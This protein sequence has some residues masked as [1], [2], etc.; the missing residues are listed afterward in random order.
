M[1]KR[2]KIKNIKSL[3]LRTV[4][5]LEVN[6]DSSYIG[7]SFV[8]HNSSP[9]V[10]NLPRKTPQIN[11]PDGKIK[12]ATNVR[13][14]LIA[15]DG[16]KL[17]A[18]DLSQAELRLMG[19]YAN[20]QVLINWVNNDYDIH[21]EATLNVFYHG[22]KMEYDS[23]NPEHKKFRKFMKS[24]NFGRLYGG[25]TPKVY[26]AMLEKMERG[27]EKPTYEV[28][29]LH[30]EW[31]FSTFWRIKEYLEEM[32]VHILT[33]HWI[34][35]KFGRRRRV[36]AA[37]SSYRFI[38]EEAVRQS[39]NCVDGLTQALTKEGWKSYDEL[40]IN[41]EFLTKNVDTGILEWQKPI[42]LNVYPNYE[43]DMYL[44]ENLENNISALTTPDHRWLIKN[45]TRFSRRNLKLKELKREENKNDYIKLRDNIYSLKEQGLNPR[46]ISIKLDISYIMVR[47]ILKLTKKPAK[48]T[49][50][51][52]KNISID[53]FMTS[54]E[55]SNTDRVK[56]IH[57]NG[58]YIAPTQNEYSNDLIEFIGWILT[59]GSLSNR[60][61][62]LTQ[63]FVT[64]PSK[65]DK[66]DKLVE[67][68][69]F[70]HIRR[71]NNRAIIWRFHIDTFNLLDR[72]I[73]SKN[74]SMEFL[75]K[76]TNIQ[77]NLLLETI[78]LGDG[79]KITTVRQ[80]H[81]DMFQALV[82]LTSQSSNVSIR[83]NVGKRS[84]SDKL[85]K[86]EYI[87]KKQPSFHINIHKRDYV[88]HKTNNGNCFKKI[89]SYKGVVWCPTL[90][91]S[92][93]VCRRFANKKYYQFITGQSQIQ[94]T[95][96]DITQ[97]A[98]LRIRKYLKDNN[99]KSRILWSVHDELD[100]ELWEPE[101]EI[102]KP[103]IPK[104][105][106]EKPYP[107]SLI[108]IK[109]DSEMEVFNNRFGD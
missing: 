44:F 94:G 80:N 77:L 95:S 103:I 104:I 75:L 10:Q 87:E 30:G 28:M 16:Y 70:S 79:I 82:V 89:E 23:K 35:S 24:G 68:L 3:G 25:G 15:R 63:S 45:T 7:N 83:D 67:R 14:I 62:T 108:N 33:H 38:Q 36:P 19:D 1:F 21:W 107:V 65:V 96:S 84:Y 64:N 86:Q 4:Y 71:I 105:M 92:T 98:A 73:P 109:L 17:G 2:T 78:Q 27:E 26:A 42:K 43:G 6:K 72:I 76:L 32:R 52:K 97:L 47:R 61:C 90:P 93:F 106:V 88:H 13:G 74:I 39:I 51:N 57:L 34:D 40:S 8:S 85:G 91:N 69:G 53:S 50:V 20:D 9:N 31:F 22:R 101:I 102:L 11:L 56:S 46:Q 81:I 49:F 5:D 99:Y 54:K 66:I 59:D 29:E 55:L 12:K 41:D 37:A 60:R 58:K 100:F 18:C 48:E